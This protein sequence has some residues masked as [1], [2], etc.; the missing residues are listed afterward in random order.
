MLSASL[1]IDQAIPAVLSHLQAGRLPEAEA[2]CRQVLDQDPCQPDALYF[3]G[4][5]ALQQGRF[6]E[7]LQ[8]G[9]RAANANPANPLPHFMAAEAERARNR[10]DAAIVH[11]KQALARNPD[12]VEARLNLG[13]LLLAQQSPSEAADCF[14]A[15]LS[16]QPHIPEIHALLGDA[17]EASGLMQEAILS[18][19]QALALQPENPGILNNLASLLK[20][21]GQLVEACTLARQAVH[22][23]P[24]NSLLYY[25]LGNVCWESGYL[26]EALTAYQRA[27]GLGFRSPAILANLGGVLQESGQ[28]EAAITAYRQCLDADP[29]F[30][31]A[32]LSLAHLLQQVCEWSGLAEHVLLIRQSLQTPC[33]PRLQ[34]S[35][36]SFL[37]LPESTPAEQKF[38][39]ERWAT[40]RYPTPPA[41]R[42]SAR[43]PDGKIH[44]AYLSSDFHEHATAYLL[45]EVLEQHDRNAFTISAFSYGPEQDC[46]MR[47]RL[48]AAC[49]HWIDLRTDSYPQA[50]QKIRDAQVDILVDLKGYTE[51]S[52]SGILALRPAP[53]QVNFLG[54]PG[55]M[56][57]PFIDYLI[58]DEFVIPPKNQADY[59]EK[60]I[61]LPNCYQPN[62][63]RRPSPP[64]PSRASCGLPAEGIV[65]CCFNHTYKITP[66]VFDLWCRLLQEI[67]GSCLWLLASNSCAEANLETE[68]RQRGISPERLIL[69]PKLP[70]AAHLARLQCADLFLDTFPVNAHTTC[71]DA[72]WM[73]VPVITRSGESFASRV[74][75]SLLHAVDLPELVT[76]SWSDYHALALRLARDAN[77]RHALRRKLQEARQHAPLFDTLRYTRC[78]EEAY[79]QMIAATN[80]MDNEKTANR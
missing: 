15:I 62:D 48:Q 47:R 9:E 53:I 78:L 3:L 46:P 63:R 21:A 56:G 64:A 68:A 31:S 36:F 34:L 80:R 19:R 75:G 52:R 39:A 30:A 37:S 11:L 13:N 43:R 72:L 59:S 27:L 20:N 14:R 49:T 10:P 2:L 29:G 33:E 38:C 35:P 17:L 16:G 73:G 6:S 54:Y 41:Q 25:N 76:E 1:P 58:A 57:A 71:S 8:W 42:I 18:Y 67:P 23:Q 32:R 70:Q 79:R 77:S 55:T 60:I 61:Y 74:A 51:N 5:A 65:F 40:S 66:D 7:A 12:F 69:A 26:N 4:Y 24:D 50:A 45:A 44:L 28:T 22:H